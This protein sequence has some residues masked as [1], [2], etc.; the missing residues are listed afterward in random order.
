MIGTHSNI[1]SGGSKRDARDARPSSG[2]EFFNFHAVFG[3]NLIKEYVCTPTLEVGGP[4]PPRLRNPEFATDCYFKTEANSK[5]I[6]SQMYQSL[7]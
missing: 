3:K 6:R 2:S 4:P 1:V 5:R 7:L